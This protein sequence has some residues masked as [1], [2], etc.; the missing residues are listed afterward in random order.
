MIIGFNIVIHG[1]YILG[2]NDA[3]DF[4]LVDVNRERF[5]L[6]TRLKWGGWFQTVY[7]DQNSVTVH[8]KY[9]QGRYGMTER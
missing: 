1:T 5:F 2:S 8:T 3:G 4:I 9:L 7:F 6:Q